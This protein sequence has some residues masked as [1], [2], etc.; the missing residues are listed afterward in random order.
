MYSSFIN[1]H[2]KEIKYQ[3][4]LQN[5]LFLEMVVYYVILLSFIIIFFQIKAIK[6]SLK[7]KKSTKYIYFINYNT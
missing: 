4:D 5:Y 7:Y 3:Y 6:L 1:V 2:F